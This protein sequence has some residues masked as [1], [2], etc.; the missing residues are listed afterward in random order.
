MQQLDIDSGAHAKTGRKEGEKGVEITKPKLKHESCILIM[1]CDLKALAGRCC[2]DSHIL[3]LQNSQEAVFFAG[4]LFLGPF[5]WPWGHVSSQFVW[6]GCR[7][8]SSSL[9]FS[10]LWYI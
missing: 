1:D 6:A 2:L 10:F 3:E 5:S 8:L 9:P 4:G 7:I